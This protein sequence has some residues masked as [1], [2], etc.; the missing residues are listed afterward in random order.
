MKYIFG[1]PHI[2]QEDIN[3]V[4]EV[5]KSGWVGCGPKV[6]AFEKALAA[7][8]GVN[9]V[10]TTSSCTS[11]L[12]LSLKSAGIK[13]GDEVITTTITFCATVNAI[14]AVGATP[15]LADI[16]YNSGNIS[17][18]SIKERISESTKAV[19]IVHLAGRPCKVEEISNLCARKNL[20]LIEDCAHAL[21]AKIEGK[22]VGTFGDYGCFSFHANKT[23]TSGEGGMLISKSPSKLEKIRKMV[24]QGLVRRSWEIFNGQELPF[25]DVVTEGFKYS[26]SDINA[27][28]G[29]SQL[30]SSLKRHTR[31][32]ELWKL[33][34]QRLSD[35]SIEIPLEIP[36]SVTHSFYLYQ[37]KCPKDGMRDL[38]ASAL[39]KRGVR[40]AIHY[41]PINQLSFYSQKFS[42]KA[43]DTPN[44]YL[45]GKSVLTLPLSSEY[46]DS[47]AHDLMDIF[48]ETYLEQEHHLNKST[49]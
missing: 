12:Y 34:S 31:R 49:R 40:A 27:A 4:T 11:A 18:Q 36:A 24:H 30:G 17:P 19:I 41:R 44:A 35:L 20:I 46:S 6:E 25:H 3:E 33:Y 1:R 47:E 28:L 22:S 32:S 43:T 2:N 10:V 21:E 14:L 26:L 9:E 39:M 13:E 45:F 38:I 37:I 15:V 8:L 23:I 16:D 5:L 42:W 7:Y 29:L 48:I